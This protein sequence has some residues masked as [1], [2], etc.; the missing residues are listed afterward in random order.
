MCLEDVHAYRTRIPVRRLDL[1]ID[2]RR[3]GHGGARVDRVV[4]LHSKRLWR[5]GV[6]DADTAKQEAQRIGLLADALQI[7]RE[8]LFERRPLSDLEEHCDS[9]P[10][11]G[12]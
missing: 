5:I 11:G 1:D 12:K 7:C 3:V 8:D 2:L 4:V 6:L 10:H 9:E